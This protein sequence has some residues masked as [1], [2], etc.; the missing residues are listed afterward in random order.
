M[1]EAIVANVQAF[2]PFNGGAGAR[3]QA[4]SE[5]A[6]V[7][8]PGLEGGSSDDKRR[9]VITNPN[10]FSVFIR[11]GNSGVEATLGSYEIV[12]GTSQLLKPPS[13]GPQAMFLAVITDGETGYVSVCSGTGV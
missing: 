3:M 10:S 4:T 13:Y 12:A 2:E 5:T 11:M 6:R 1:T 8:I 9:V 7:A